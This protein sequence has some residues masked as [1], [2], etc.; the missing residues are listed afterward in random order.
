MAI[1]ARNAAFY[2]SACIRTRDGEWCDVRI[3]RATHPPCVYG[4]FIR[5]AGGRGVRGYSGGRGRS[6]HTQSE[7]S[8]PEGHSE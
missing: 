8:A 3:H 1:S 2:L 7:E 6:S 4:L 5:A